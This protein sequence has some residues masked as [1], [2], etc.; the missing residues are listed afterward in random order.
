[1]LFRLCLVISGALSQVHSNYITSTTAYGL[2]A[3]KEEKADAHYVFFTNSPHRF[4]NR[5]QKIKQKGDPHTSHILPN[6]P[7]NR[8]KILSIRAASRTVENTLI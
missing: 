4:L 1:M 7:K 8:S 5:A 2:N 6:I 3:K